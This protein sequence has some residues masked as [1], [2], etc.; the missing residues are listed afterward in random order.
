MIGAKQGENMKP[1]QIAEAVEIYCGMR[2]DL[3]KL[4][5]LP[6]NCTPANVAEAYE[7]QQVLNSRLN[8]LGLG[9]ISGH[10]IGCTSKVMQDYLKIDEP[11]SGGI[12]ANTIF[13]EKGERGH[14]AYIRP[15]VECEIAIGLGATLGVAGAP[16]DVESV[17]S[18]VESVMAA[19]EI[20]DDRFADYTKLAL[21]IMLADDF[22]N[23]GCVLGVP[24]KDWRRRD[25]AKLRCEMF[26]NGASIGFGFGGDVM[27]HPLNVLA[28]LANSLIA[29]GRE[30]RAGEIVLTGS[31]VQTYWCEP[32]DEARVEIET[33]GT[34]EMRFTPG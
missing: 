16:Y 18:A 11:C 1:D 14:Y 25:I 20:V 23:S 32:G 28:W 21:P 24:V 15:G 17:A 31:S 30:L 26:I 10:K 5:R 4:D 3:D 27:G 34:A 2:L 33:L 12:Y 6:K 29:R 19:I 13:H 22:F 8:E 9:P 7:I